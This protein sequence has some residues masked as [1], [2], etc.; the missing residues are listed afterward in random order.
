MTPTEDFSLDGTLVHQ[1]FSMGQKLEVKGK[2][3]I[4][5]VEYSLAKYVGS[6]FEYQAL[7]ISDDGTIHTKVGSFSPQVGGLIPVIYTYTITPPTAKMVRVEQ[8]KVVTEKGYQNYELLYNGSDKN[9][10]YFTYREFSP[11][12]LART[13]FYQNLTYEA[14]A[15]TIRFKGFKIDVIKSN[16]EE[17]KFVITEDA[18]KS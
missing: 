12:G 3:V 18:I 17:I 8:E 14:N 15:K 2:V 16:N 4:D 5:S 1:K 13:A 6:D 7:L 9:S 10:M 11:D